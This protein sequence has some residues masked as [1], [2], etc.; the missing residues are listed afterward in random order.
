MP[1]SK[2]WIVTTSG[3]RPLGDIAK[4]AKQAGFSVGDV[5]S[6]IGCI[7]GSGSDAVAKKLRS[8]PGVADVSPED[9]VDIGPP[10]AP[11]TW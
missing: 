11:D 10:G 6:E 2:R 3:E 5:L 4:A 7:T 8:I 9:V 1:T